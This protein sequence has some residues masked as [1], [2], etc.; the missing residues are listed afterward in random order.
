MVQDICHRGRVHNIQSTG[1]SRGDISI[2]KGQGRKKEAGKCNTDKWD[3]TQKESNHNRT[4]RNM[5][6]ENKSGMKILEEY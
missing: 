6:E 4:G 3:G 5:E 2:A 1:R